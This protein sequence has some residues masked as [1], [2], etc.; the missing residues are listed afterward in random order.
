MKLSTQLGYAGGFHE[1]VE[2]V[3]ELE[4]AGLDTVWVAEAYGFDAVSFMGYLAAKTER[5]EIAS[6]ILPIYTRTPALLA[7]TAAGV[8]ALSGGRAMLG[9]GASGPQVIEGW[10]GVPYD[11]PLTRTREIVDICRRIWK[12][13]RLEFAGKKYQMPLPKGQGTGFGKSLK[14]ITHPVRDDI[15]ITIAAL[16]PKSVEMTAEI[17]DG[18]LPILFHPTKSRE[19]WGAALAAGAAKREATRAPLRIFAGG[20]VAFGEGIEDLRNRARPMMAL[21]VGGMGARGKNFYNDLFA[22]YGYEKEAAEIQDLYLSGKKREAEA[23]IPGSFLDETS[24][25]GSEGYVRDRLVELKEAGV[26]NLNVSFAGQTV[27]DRV[28]T[29]AQ[30]RE[31]VASI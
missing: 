21:Y 3:R 20:A 31:I 26:N 9:L 5:V 29:L 22:S 6:G 7:M 10:H 17:A 19:R 25:V 15:P 23:A 27:S 14:M 12:R 4:Q 2:E 8:D 28:R 13:E 30:L 1:T 16:T 24:L 11:A 18:W